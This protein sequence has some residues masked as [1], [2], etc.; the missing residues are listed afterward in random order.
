LIA[1][2]ILGLGT[3][4]PS[5]A[6]EQDAFALNLANA[7]GLN[8][9]QKS[10]L[11]RL[12]KNTQIQNRYTVVPDYQRDFQRGELYHSSFP[13]C[14]PGSLERN[15]IYKIAAP[16]LAAQAAIKALKEWGGEPQEITHVIS[17]S[18][19]GMMA[20]GIEFL[21]VDQLALPRSCSKLGVNFMGCFGAFR[22][23]AVARSF[24]LENPNHRILLVC[25]EL[26]SLHMQMTQDKSSFISNA[27]F[28]DGAA[29]VVV[30]ACPKPLEKPLWEIRK[31]SS[32]AIADSKEEMTWEIGNH[33]FVMGLS[34]KTPLLFKKEIYE[35][36]KA[37]VQHQTSLSNCL[38]A[39]HPGGKAILNAIAAV[40][41]LDS[42]L[43]F[44][45]SWHVLR[46]FGNMSSATFLFVLEE[47]LKAQV[48][49][50]KDWSIGLGFGPGLDLEGVLLKNVF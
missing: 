8:E 39:P 6:V 3:A 31:F 15:A 4:V 16:E 27:L 17:V 7:M 14:I 50:A 47:M 23:L 35:F 19:T 24:S 21:L 11:I 44:K 41:G 26:C 38:W 25:T 5:Y 20:P 33:G 48:S 10:L 34:E 32:Y 9:G 49:G 22:G 12:F 29:A 45:S 42:E 18:C 43:D 30:G 13:K 46:N 1:S 40:C 2:H 37:L 36:C 28:S